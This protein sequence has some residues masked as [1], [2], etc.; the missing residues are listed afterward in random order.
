[1]NYLLHISSSPL[2][3]TA[4]SKLVILYVYP[5]VKYHLVKKILN[6]KFLR[7]KLKLDFK[8]IEQ[9][10]TYSYTQFIVRKFDKR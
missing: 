8:F 4:L 9:R 10:R 6:A 7:Y 1:M 5:C 2:N 3:Q